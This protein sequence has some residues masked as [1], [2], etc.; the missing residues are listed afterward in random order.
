[1]G[2]HISLSTCFISQRTC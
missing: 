2:S 1:M